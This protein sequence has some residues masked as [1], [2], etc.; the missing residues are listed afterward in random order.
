MGGR[1]DADILLLQVSADISKLQKQFDK[2]VNTVNSGSKKMEDRA[3]RF[4]KTFGN[5]NDNA[6]QKLSRGF[7]AAIGDNIRDLSKN[8]LMAG[9]MLEGFGAAGV[10]AAAGIGA[11]VLVLGQ[12]KAAVAFGDAIADSATK[13]GVSTDTLQE[14]R[15][16]I[17]QV[18]GDYAD[19]DEALS[20]FTQTLGKAELGFSK[21]ALKPFAALGFS[22]DD[23]NNFAS[24]DDALKAILDRL[25]GIKDEEKRQGLAAALGLEK[26]I[27]LAREG[28]GRLDE[29]RAAAHRLGYVMDADLI[30]KAGEANDKLED[31]QAI[32]DVQL[33]SAFVDLAPVIL[34]VAG[35]IASAAREVNKIS[36]DVKDALPVMQRWFSL[37][38]GGGKGRDITRY[39]GPAGLLNLTG[40]AA[41]SALGGAARAGRLQSLKTGVKDMLAGGQVD[42]PADFDEVYG[43]KKPPA[44]DPLDQ[45]GGGGSKPRDTYAAQVETINGLL[46]SANKDLLQAQNNLTG[47]IEAR[48]Q[49]ERDIAAQELAQDLARLAKVKADFD[50]D[51]GLSDP[52]RKGLKAKADEAMVA[53]RKA[54]EARV[55]LINR[56]ADWAAE[57]RAD[58][59][60]QEIRD[61]EIRGLQQQASLAT[62]QAERTRIE[63]QIL[64]IQQAEMV[65]LTGKQI[66]R[67]EETGAIS[68]E[69]GARRSAA[70]GQSRADDRERFSVDH[71]SPTK[72][73]LRSIQDLDTEMQ[74]AG[75]QA[76]EGLAGG[77]AEAIV[78]AES[79]ADVGAS[80]F[81]QF[82]IEMLRLLIKAGM[83]EAA[84][85]FGFSGGGYLGGY[86]DG[87]RL[88][89]GP[90][91][92]TSDS[93]LATN[94]KGKFARFSDGE[95]VSTAKATRKHRALLEAI[96][97]GEIDRY[98]TG[99]MIGS[100]PALSSLGG[101]RGVNQYVTLDN[102][103][104][105]IW[106]G[107]AAKL[108]AYTDARAMDAATSGANGGAA[109]SR[110]RVQRAA[111]SK[112]GRS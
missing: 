50:K 92:G 89:S 112:L 69:E 15:Y 95:F 5:A 3:T 8:A 60:R 13:V 105:L 26:F 25:A 23:L 44:F 62:T 16:A 67:L 86:A 59:T 49:N 6:V 80:V 10:A 83:K 2:A 51:T 33:K 101:G 68:P 103:G 81:K 78:N 31:L 74:N 96:N 34:N 77:L 70:A 108:M 79:L 35:A 21:K 93:I 1:T 87:G 29:L 22:K 47:D 14:Y 41:R 17:H 64:K 30:A 102:R 52:E 57:D 100:M 94:G 109:L 39:N 61:A 40:D 32:A 11:L 107:E 55:D 53:A 85:T 48:A 110:F 4:A 90:G 98:A 20:K 37:L 71:E 56:E 19:A 63:A 28:S 9:T 104:A 18:G 91:T 7:G 82:E 58:D 43:A 73:Y 38:N 88:L 106:E 45:S 111:S 36:Q 54:S 84:T 65:H 76:F 72:K 24:A 27:P 46:A 99:G 97:S 75:V 42:R 12:A 66:S